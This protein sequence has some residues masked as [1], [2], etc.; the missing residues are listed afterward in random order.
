MKKR[1]SLRFDRLKGGNI[2]GRKKKKRKCARPRQYRPWPTNIGI[3]S[4]KKQLFGPK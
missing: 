2:K 3:L 1:E 4:W